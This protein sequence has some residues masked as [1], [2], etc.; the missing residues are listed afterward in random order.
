MA[1]KISSIMATEIALDVT[2][3]TR[4]LKALKQSVGIVNKAVE[5]QSANLAAAGNSYEAVRA[6][7]EGL[8]NVISR[9]REVI[10]R[11]EAEQQ[12]QINVARNQSQ[13]ISD[14]QQKIRETKAA[15]DEEAQ[16]NGRQTQ[17]YKDLDEQLKIYRSDLREANNIGSRLNSTTN[18]LENARA[19]MARYVAEQRQANVEARQLS[20]SGWHRMG[21]AILTANRHIQDTRRAVGGLKGVFAGTFAGNAL[22]Q[23]ASTA[24]GAVKQGIAGVVQ[25]GTEFDKQQQ[26]MQASWDTLMNSS[27]KATGMRQSIIDMSNALGQPV[28]LTDE[29]SQQFYHVFDNQPETEQ[30]TRSFLTMGDAIG[31][32]SDRL[33]QVGMDFTH[34]LS[35]SKLQ[36]GDLNQ[37]TDAF[38]MFGNALLNYER[39]IQHNGKLTMADLRKQISAGKIQSKDAEAVMNQLGQKY[40]K[41][42]ENLMSTLPGMERQIKAK[43]SQLSGDVMSPILKQ[44]SP[45]YKAV[46]TW[47]KD[48]NTDT[49]FKQ[50]GQKVNAGIQ[51]VM[52][53]FGG[54]SNQYTIING[55]NAAVQKAGEAVQTVTNWIAQHAQA[56][57]ASFN[58]VGAAG[59][60]AF[61]ILGASIR[62]VI[63][64]LNIFAGGA[65]KSGT[66]S[67]STAQQLNQLANSLNRLS[68][69]RSRVQML[70]RAL[71]AVFIVSKVA[72][73]ARTIGGLASTIAG[74]FVGA[75]SRGITAYR[76]G[77]TAA[78]IFRAALA[79]NP[80]VLAAGAIAGI[81]V[82][83]VA[84]YRHN[85]KFRDFMRGLW[86]ITKDAAAKI[87]KI[88][89]AYWM[90]K[91]L[92][93]LYKQSPAFRKFVNGL[94]NFAK[95]VFGTLFKWAKEGLSEI[96]KGIKWAYDKIADVGKSGSLKH[97]SHRY[98][99]GT[100][101]GQ[102]EFAVVNDGSSQHWRE[103]MYYNGVLLP[104]SNRRNQVAYI[105]QG[106]QVL[107]GET[108]HK[109]A[110]AQG[111]KHYASGSGELTSL[112][113]GISDSGK[114]TRAEIF[115]EFMKKLNAE[116][117]KNLRKFQQQISKAQ[118]AAAKAISKAQQD[119]KQKVAKAHQ[120]M[121]QKETQAR[122]SEQQKLAQARQKLAQRLAQIAANIAQRKQKIEQTRD[123]KVAKANQTLAQRQDKAKASK[124][125]RTQKADAAYAAAK[126]KHKDDPEA[127]AKATDEHNK[128]LAAISE[129]F[130]K[131]M[132][133]AR[134]SYGKTIEAS[135]T[136]WQKSTNSMLQTANSQ[137]ATAQN[138]F[139]TTT[140]KAQSSLQK[141]L[142]S[143]T[144]SYE[145]AAS[146][147]KSASQKSINSA[148]AT[149]SQ[150][151]NLAKEN[152]ER[153][154]QWRL[155]NIRQLRSGFAMYAH[156]G[157]ATQ[158]SVFGEAGM[159]AAIPMDQ[160]KQG[161]AWQTLQKVINFYSGSSDG[162]TPQGTQQQQGSSVDSEKLFSMMGTM[163]QLLQS[164]VQG[165]GD[166]IQ[167][168]RGIQGYDKDKANADVSSFISDAWNS[169]LT[170]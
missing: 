69:N 133:N 122:A 137:K 125:Q 166:Q 169:G 82:A 143:A 52:A 154:K 126:K 124:E 50:L 119:M 78:G 21:D 89:P 49:E 29:L 8:N 48:P 11:L 123:E 118:E 161:D 170:M 155:D 113:N 97:P 67:K 88:F 47:V 14:I 121:A 76:N 66:Q 3:A 51:T 156:G 74:P 46:S 58:L 115:K 109:V 92:Q 62:V 87:V 148:R 2:P 131:A 27:S 15:R 120:D 100:T 129:A 80:Y 83:L 117:R 152:I 33:Q 138:S 98:A 42:S 63:S 102:G 84:L 34:M 1:E 73:F 93:N 23:G 127:L 41:S 10:S 134:T 135:E 95:A 149:E 56:I 168:T 17:A 25:A 90:I 12:R 79:I 37:I 44:Q 31:L 99:S 101:G 160:M 116:F 30:L 94:A 110:S 7:A 141:A 60:A 71:A 75:I 61:A 19:K 142:Q 45:I 81:T 38:P 157:I 26:V 153:L 68:Q 39:Q 13:A 96:G 65:R 107:D 136:S 103:M 111:L 140:G 145:T 55:L 159:E 150:K 162:S 91:A 59:R 53:A 9:Q 32:S 105:P 85:A 163:V 28:E 70:G 146:K 139:N 132:A 147:A 20:T 24:L 22:A 40:K 72:G 16:A 158:P 64:M 165:Q 164:V 104:F 18:Q 36:L 4:S 43:V 128:R 106:A 108:A 35:S 151:V 54:G 77:A 167:A 112:V 130:G 57:K 5:A 6:K 86:I 144:Q 114:G